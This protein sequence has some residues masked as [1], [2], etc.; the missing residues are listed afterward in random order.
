MTEAGPAGSADTIGAE[1]AVEAHAAGFAILARG[2]VGRSFYPA[3]DD[4]L[5]DRPSL[6]ARVTLDV[7]RTFTVWDSTR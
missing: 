5:R 4:A 3:L 2:A 6:G 1:L 7:Q